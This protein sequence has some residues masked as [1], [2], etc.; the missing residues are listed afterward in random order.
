MHMRLP[1]WMVW[2][3]S[4]ESVQEKIKKMEGATSDQNQLDQIR[5]MMTHTRSSLERSKRFKDKIAAAGDSIGKLNDALSSAHER[6]EVVKSDEFE[7]SLRRETELRMYVVKKI[8]D[9][10]QKGQGE[11]L[12]LSIRG[13]KGGGKGYKNEREWKNLEEKEKRFKEIQAKRRCF[14]QKGFKGAGGAEK[15]KKR[16]QQRSNLLNLSNLL[17][18]SRVSSA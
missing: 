8:L 3:S 18:K 10:I 17:I 5:N 12:K 15:R 1:W 2:K 6:E 11:I 9:D 16:Q 4:L 14:L 7:E 13:R